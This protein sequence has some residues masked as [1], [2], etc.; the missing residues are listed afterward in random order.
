[1]GIVHRDLHSD[2]IL[3]H[4]NSIKLVDFGLSKPIESISAK[5]CIKIIGVL[6]YID[7]KGFGSTRKNKGTTEKVKDVV[8]DT[9]KEHSE[10][11]TR[12]RKFFTPSNPNSQK[13]KI[14]KGD[15]DE[16]DK[17]SLGEKQKQD[18]EYDKG[19][20]SDSIIV[21]DHEPKVNDTVVEEIVEL[22]IRITNEGKSR[23]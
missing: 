2:N 6:P 15:K 4:Q 9:P 23:D 16:E 11:Y 1:M 20:N 14:I 21:V 18:L 12:K 8:E 7:P 3:I 22:F 17:N 10:L 13:I 19:L 5:I